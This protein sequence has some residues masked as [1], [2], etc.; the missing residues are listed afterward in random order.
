MDLRTK[1]ACSA[2]PQIH[3]C[4]VEDEEFS[5]ELCFPNERFEASA[6]AEALHTSNHL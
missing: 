4:R 1:D 6:Q 3:Q 5:S 2:P